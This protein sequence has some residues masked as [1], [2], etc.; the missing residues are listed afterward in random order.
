MASEVLN[1]HGRVLPSS[2]HSTV[3]FA[4][5]RDGREVEGESNIAAEGSAVTS[6]RLVPEA[7]AASPGVVDAI[8]RAQ[9][10]VLGPGS[11]YTSILPNLLV[12]EIAE[13]LRTTK[14]FRILVVNAMTEPGETEGLG[15]ADHARAV[16]DHVGADSLDAVLLSDDDVPESIL[17]R[18]AL[19]GAQRVNP[20][21]P[22]LTNMVPRV[23]R[24]NV[25]E[26][27]TKVRHDPYKTAGSILLEY[28][29]WSQ[30][31]KGRVEAL[32]E[33]TTGERS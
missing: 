16:L 7:P 29:R 15:A 24:R 11:L 2:L 21:D 22:E 12:P 27:G 26:T 23:A 6:I 19:E 31:D 33:T 5:L 20:E 9:I 10:V 25:L 32:Q 28:R 1:I 14:A 18:Y 8:R 17:E 3:L 13:A 30:G 4:T